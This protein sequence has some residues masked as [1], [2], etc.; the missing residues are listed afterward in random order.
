MLCSH[1]VMAVLFL[2]GCNAVPQRTLDHG[3]WRHLEVVK[4][5]ENII[6]FSNRGQD[7]VKPSVCKIHIKPSI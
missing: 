7:A 3:I 2:N 5:R 4:L 1:L 6:A